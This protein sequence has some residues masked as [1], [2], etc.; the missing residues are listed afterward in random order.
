MKFRIALFLAVILSGTLVAQTNIGFTGFGSLSHIDT[1]FDLSNVK[2]LKS[3]PGIGASVFIE[4]ELGDNFALETGAQYVQKGFRIRQR[5]DTEIFGNPIPIGYTVDTRL[6]Y[7][8]VPLLLTAKFGGP[9][10]AGFVKAGPRI[11]YGTHGRII[12][13]ANL[14]LGLNVL[15]EEIPFETIGLKRWDTGLQFGAGFEVPLDA[16]SLL[17]QGAYDLGLTELISM[18]ILEAPF[19]N[20]SIMVGIG[21]KMPLQ[22]R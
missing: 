8:Q 9:R 3:I 17:I 14:L 22:Q 1:P 2:A 21:W 11:A 18:G 20:R 7:L 16:G 13:K 19:K 12:G 15:N 4:K 5:M 6:N 10:L